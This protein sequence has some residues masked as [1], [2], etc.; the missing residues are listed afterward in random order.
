MNELGSK[1]HI[2]YSKSAAKLLD[3]LKSSGRTYFVYLLFMVIE[4][5]KYFMIIFSIYT[6]TR[7]VLCWL[8]S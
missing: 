1:H 4:T 3:A 5:F 2:F 8:R 7:L 6:H